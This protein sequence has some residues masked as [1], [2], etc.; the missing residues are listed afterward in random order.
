[1]RNL[2]ANKPLL[3]IAVSLLA[4][5]SIGFNQSLSG[6]E[7]NNSVNNTSTHNTNIDNINNNEASNTYTQATFQP[8]TEA[9][10]HQHLIYSLLV[11]E[12]AASRNLPNVALT[13]YLE[14]AQ[15]TQ[16]P[17]IAQQAT[18]WA[19]QFQAP[20]AAIL[21]SEIWAK[22]AP[23]DLQA[24]MVATTLLIGQS[25]QKAIPYLTRALEIN[26]V[27]V[28]QHIVAIQSRLS[29]KSAE[30]L[31]NAL[32]LIAKSRPKDA[33]AQVA[34]AQAA[35]T[36][37]D[38]K[39]ANLLA[40]SALQINPNLTSAL[41]LKARLIRHE[42][43]SDARALAFLGERVNQFPQNAELRLFYATAL[44]DARKYEEAV[45]HLKL[46]AQD[47]NYGG[48]ALILL[49]E[50]A[51]NNNDLNASLDFFRKALA[52]PNNKDQAQ[53]L[54]GQLF[55]FK[56]QKQ[57]AI[58]WYAGV[59]RGAYHVNAILRAVALLKEKREYTKALKLIHEASPTTLEEQKL[60]ILS[61]VDV[62]SSNRQLEDA[63]SLIDEVLTKLPEDPDI[64]FSH[65]LVALEMHQY[66]IAEKD[67]RNI[68]ERNQKNTD[69]LNALGYTLSLQKDRRQEATKYILQ[70]L[71]IA[72]NNPAYLD[73]LGWVYYQMG[74]L[75][76]AATYLKK[77]IELSSDPDIAAHLGE[78]LWKMNQR[79]E[80]MMVLSK[81]L[82]KAPDHALLND[83][84]KRLNIQ[85]KKSN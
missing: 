77:A 2:F 21:G 12:L 38:M 63:Y 58:V 35:A 67:L 45:K 82:E 32:L 49:G 11:A 3:Y 41:Q 74:E 60:L 53:Y 10:R 18:Q 40:D 43:T 15:L 64:L 24:Q 33:Q 56:G 7:T 23:D 47:K 39:N 84:I 51:A 30:N 48:Q 26:P 54:L 79:E 52:Y 22:S 69:A 70:A 6:K 34:A 19:I 66:D 68:L 5:G 4:I 59:N 17:T 76:E 85:I 1:M 14:A 83:T 73:T 81:A 65:S 9:E 42:D 62:L 36:V 16:D 61:E 55:E 50:V 13:H 78:V 37:G 44:L 46:L 28:N 31:K 80:A 29:E 57:E 27:E 71:E 75:N 8:K 25:V 20:M 72:P